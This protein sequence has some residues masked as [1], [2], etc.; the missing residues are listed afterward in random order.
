MKHKV[1][2]VDDEQSNILALTHMLRPEYDVYASKD[3]RDAIETTLQ[4]MPDIILLDVIMPEMDGYSVLT[5]LKKDVR[6]ADIPVVFITGLSGTDNEEKGFMLG[7]ADYIVKPFIPGIVKLRV[8]NQLQLVANMRMLMEKEVAEKSHLAKINFL[9]D[10]NHNMLTPM[11]IIMGMTQI[12]KRAKKLD[13]VKDYLGDI[14]IASKELLTLL[15][16]LLSFEGFEDE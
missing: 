7:A 14:D 13:E 5:A 6:T 16:K 12:A 2:V 10:M 8:K 15:K 9:L 4:L 3:G 1:L 11:N